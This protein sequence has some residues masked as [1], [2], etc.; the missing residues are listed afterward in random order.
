MPVLSHDNKTFTAKTFNFHIVPTTLWKQIDVEVAVKKI[1]YAI[2][3][4][5]M[6]THVAS[7][8][9]INEKLPEKAES[10]DF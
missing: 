2:I 4:N 10:L 6:L 8:I 7:Q 5:L 3:S 1:V 9:P